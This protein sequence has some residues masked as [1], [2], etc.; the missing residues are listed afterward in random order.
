MVCPKCNEIL[1]AWDKVCKKC[2]AEIYPQYDGMNGAHFDMQAGVWQTGSTGQ[3][4]ENPNDPTGYSNQAYENPNDLARYSDQAYENPLSH[5][6]APNQHQLN[7]HNPNWRDNSAT[8]ISGGCIFGVVFGS[9]AAFCLCVWIVIKVLFPW[10][11]EL[12]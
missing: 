4:Y 1:G 8:R 3:S 11:A 7:F 5:P 12:F 6:P 10:L 9:I 2:G